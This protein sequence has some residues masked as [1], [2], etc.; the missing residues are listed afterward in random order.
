M[1]FGEEDIQ[2]SLLKIKIIEKLVT[3]AILQVNAEVHQIVN[4]I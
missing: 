3:V 1:T 4:V 2:Y